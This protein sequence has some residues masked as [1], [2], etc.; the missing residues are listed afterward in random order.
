MK[1]YYTQPYDDDDV[2]CGKCEADIDPKEGLYHCS[3]DQCEE[4]YHVRCWKDHDGFKKP[5][6]SQE[7]L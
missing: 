2:Y 6:I 1:L 5:Q 7:S 3:Q 4:D